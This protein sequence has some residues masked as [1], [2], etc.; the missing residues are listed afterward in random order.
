M[1]SVAGLGEYLA[2]IIMYFAQDSAYAVLIVLV[3]GYTPVVESLRVT[4][5]LDHGVLITQ[6]LGY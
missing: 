6:L 3:Q 1:L 2:L 4:V 5:L